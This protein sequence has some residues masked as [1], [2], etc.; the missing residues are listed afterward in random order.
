MQ[1]A[2]GNSERFEYHIL[3]SDVVNEG[4]KLDMCSDFP[5]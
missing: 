5:Y 2:E 4:E 3:F 1:R